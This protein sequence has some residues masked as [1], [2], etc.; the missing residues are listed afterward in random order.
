MASL[1]YIVRDYRPDDKE[2]LRELCRD[3]WSDRPAETF[4]RRWWWSQDRPP[5]K[6]A[7]DP[8]SRAL[9]GFC[10][11]A[12]F[13]LFFQGRSYPSAWFA[14]FF[15]T[16]AHQGKGLGRQLAGAVMEG[17]ELAASL[18]HNE[19]A[20]SLFKKMDWKEH[21][22]ADLYLYPWLLIPGVSRWQALSRKKDAYEIKVDAWPLSAPEEFDSLWRQAR[23]R[24]APL[25]CRDAAA[26]ERR[27]GPLKRDYKM[28]RC[29]KDGALVG[30]MVT[31]I[32]PAGAIRSLPA[33][34]TGLIVDFLVRPEESSEIF[35]AL[36]AG[37]LQ[38]LARDGASCIMSLATTEPFA[39][40]LARHGFLHAASP[41]IGPRLSRL[42]ARFA[43]TGPAC[44][45]LGPAPWYLTL[46]DADLDLMWN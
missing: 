26:L 34:P 18:N 16:E 11:F 7:E 24:W 13:S 5:L 29:C 4:E 35:R 15:I 45:A 30:Y 32:A 9:V 23:D 21:R 36:L 41:L 39:R 19:A 37:A 10:G 42:K 44:A 1:P 25:A 38:H 43:F 14:D 17:F 2:R 6:L 8:S 12:P 20:L 33:R 27:Y 28:L 46:G 22:V 3:V 40:E 31:R